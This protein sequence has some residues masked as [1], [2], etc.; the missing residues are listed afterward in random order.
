MVSKALRTA[1]HRT[2]RAAHLPPQLRLLVVEDDVII[3]ASLVDD[4]SEFGFVV[5]GP[6]SNLTDAA[7]TAYTEVL[8]CALIDIGLGAESAIP[9]VQILTDRHIPVVIMTGANEMADGITPDIPVLLKPFSV[10]ELRL[11]LERVLDTGSCRA[12]PVHGAA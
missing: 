11:A 7:A 10:E 2:R 9:V 12:P 6:A 4:L 1:G 8:D 3:A 5:V